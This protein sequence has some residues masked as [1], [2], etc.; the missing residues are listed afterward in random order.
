MA[1]LAC[2]GRRMV[3]PWFTS[4]KRRSP[5]QRRECTQC[6]HVLAGQHAIGSVQAPTPEPTASP[7]DARECCSGT[8]TLR[9]NSRLHHICL[10]RL[11]AGTR[12][13]V[14][15][16]DRH[17]RIIT[18]EGDLLRDLTLDP[19]RDYQPR[20]AKKRPQRAQESE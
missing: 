5:G 11:L 19:S 12:V 8:I 20:G 4:T 3:E 1:A 6:P 16:D 18:R 10:G 13:Y 7:Y 17:V 15:A 14:L 9:H 2:K